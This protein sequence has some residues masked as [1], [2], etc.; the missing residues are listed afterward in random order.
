MLMTNNV[1]SQ[2]DMEGEKH[3]KNGVIIRHLSRLADVRINIYRLGTTVST[4]IQ[5][6]SGLFAQFTVKLQSFVQLV[7]AISH[8]WRL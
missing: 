4:G 1:K 7:N 6:M 2:K 8:S 3:S 5:L